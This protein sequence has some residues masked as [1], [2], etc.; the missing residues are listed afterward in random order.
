MLDKIATLKKLHQEFPRFQLDTMIKI[1]DCI[2]ESDVTETG[3]VLTSKKNH[4]EDKTS[5]NTVIKLENN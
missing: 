3:F 2:V 1:L 4:L 5:K